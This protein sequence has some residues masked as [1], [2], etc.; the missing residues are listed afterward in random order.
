MPG[1]L[2]RVGVIGYP[3]DHSLS[4]KLFNYWLKKYSLNGSYEA[5]AVKT[6]E[7]KTFLSKMTDLGLIGF[8]V[9][10]PHKQEIINYVDHLSESARRIGAV[11]T[12]SIKN[13]L[14]FGDNTDGFG[15]IENL[16]QNSNFHNFINGD[17]IVLGAG[18][19]ARA[20]VNALVEVKAKNIK[21]INRTQE[22]AEILANNFGDTVNVLNWKKR[23][24]SLKNA[25]LVVNT[26][27][28]GMRG[29]DQLD[30]NLNVLPKKALINDIVY[31]PI[32]T[33][34]LKDAR[35]RGN[36]TVDGIGMLLHQARPA[37][38]KW[39]GKDPLVTDKL[40]N[41]MLDSKKNWN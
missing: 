32:E 33:K 16:K 24:E 41:Y 19:A 37:F 29:N 35:V 13:G 17:C 3:I 7:I 21:I 28:L 18:G 39:F 4:P 25:S 27:I 8:N 22:K 12:V 26:T 34:L 14:F 6:N 9:T 40:R 36:P 23:H 15:F 2:L 31:V 20:I 10:V 5:Y 1:S 11:N 38:L 30:L